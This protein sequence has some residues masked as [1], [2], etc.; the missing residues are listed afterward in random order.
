[1]LQLKSA[2]LCS[3]CCAFSVVAE[4]FIGDLRE[5]KVAGGIHGTLDTPPWKATPT[6][7]QRDVKGAQRGDLSLVLVQSRCV[8]LH[9]FLLESKARRCMLEPIS[10]ANLVPGRLKHSR[11]IAICLFLNSFI[12]GREDGLSNSGGQTTRSRLQIVVVPIGGSE[13]L[14]IHNTTPH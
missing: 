4:T 12:L 2:S 3:D 6:R 5:R 13:T 11:S 7:G 14:T 8:C 1:M 10:R 9:T